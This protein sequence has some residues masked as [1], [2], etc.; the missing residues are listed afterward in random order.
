MHILLCCI[1]LEKVN[2]HTLQKAALA[3]DPNK[4]WTKRDVA[5]HIGI[6]G[7]GDVIVGCPKRVCDQLEE[8][9]DAGDIDGFNL[10]YA[11]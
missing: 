4:T 6:G 1:E 9:V 10:C 2:V 7:R 8:L 5:E 3:K 11:V